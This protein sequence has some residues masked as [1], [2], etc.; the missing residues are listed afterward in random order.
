MND[1]FYRTA[2]GIAV[3]LCGL[4][5]LCAYATFATNDYHPVLMRGLFMLLGSEFLCLVAA[6]KGRLWQRRAALLVGAY[7]VI[8]L[9]EIVTRLKHL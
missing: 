4:G 1:L 3:I 8:P 2:F 7:A 5:S 9:W 6:W